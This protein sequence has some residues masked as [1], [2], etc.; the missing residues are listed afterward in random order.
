MGSQ[1]AA[2][3]AR[4]AVG[5][6]GTVLIIEDEE[7][8]R[9]A[10]S[11]MLRKRGLSVIEAD[12]GAIGA[13]LYQNMA[14]EIDAVLLDLTLPGMFGREVLERMRRIRPD[15]KVILTS[16]FSRERALFLIGGE[17]PWAYIKKPYQFD[18]LSSLI[19]KACMP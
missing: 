16:G 19:R 5:V 8:I 9:I 18:E 3:T 13:N 11:R 14:A 12:D 6:C 7:G 4:E 17:C 10:V 15:V 1:N 2:A